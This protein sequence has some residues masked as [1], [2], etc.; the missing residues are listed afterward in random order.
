[1]N[2]AAAS[3]RNCCGRVATGQFVKL[4]EAVR[5]IAAQ[6]NR[7]SLGHAEIN[8]TGVSTSVARL[9]RHLSNNY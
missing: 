2:T 7:R 6:S 4:G 5:I 9:D 3:A 8:D 1:V